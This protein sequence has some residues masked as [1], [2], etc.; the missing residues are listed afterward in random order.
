MKKIKLILILI[1][2]PAMVYSQS[3]AI[4][5]GAEIN[6]TLGADVCASNYGNI[7]GNLTGAGT[8][9][10]GVL[11]IQIAS[12]TAAIENKHNIKMIW[13]TTQEINNSG[14]DIQRKQP[15]GDWNKIGFV[16]G[17][18]NSNTISTYYYTDLNLNKG[19]YTYR[20]KQIDY[21]GN[22]EY[23]QLGNIISIINPIDF[24]VAQNYPNP[25]N[26][27][28]RIDYQIPIDGKVVLTVFD[29]TGKEVAT[30]VNEIKVSGYYSADF[31]GNNLSSGVYFYRISAEGSGQKFSKTMKMVLV[32]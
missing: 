8:Q 13:V 9:C 30:L 25:S 5:A 27:N 12:F 16:T 14:F 19:S 20:L 6:K 7:T 4:D 28:T 24:S 10:D 18:G 3:I 11:P 1:F 31:Y 2:I 17:K 29:I 23:Y 15:D 32:K 22:F 21:N 26:P